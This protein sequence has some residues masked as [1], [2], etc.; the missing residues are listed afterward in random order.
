MV[1]HDAN[2]SCLSSADKNPLSLGTCVACSRTALHF[3]TLCLS[4]TIRGS[5]NGALHSTLLLLWTLSIVEF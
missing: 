1:G 2:Y 5:N 4:T 3:L